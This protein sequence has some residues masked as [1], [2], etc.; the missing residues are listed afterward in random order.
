MDINFDKALI[1]A[2]K[3]GSVIFGSKKSIQSA[4]SGKVKLLI[5][6]KNC[7]EYI[8]KSVSCISNETKTY[9][10]DGT[11]KQLG[12]ICGK[13]FTIAL[14]GILDEGESEILSFSVNQNGMNK[15][16]VPNAPNRLNG[17]TIIPLSFY[18]TT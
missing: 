4:N 8:F 7:P 12:L 18:L 9:V 10:Y 1:K 13:P 11:S 6:A 2:I 15:N 16:S 5:I 3:S 17:T 14:M